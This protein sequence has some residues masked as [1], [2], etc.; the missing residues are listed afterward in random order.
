[1]HS[2][3]GMA[4]ARERSPRSRVR[5]LSAAGRPVPPGV[6]LAALAV[7]GAV[8]LLLFFLG[9]AEPP[10]LNA[11]PPYA[12]PPAVTANLMG[13][14]WDADRGPEVGFAVLYV[15]EQCPHCR[16]ELG[17]WA[18]LRKADEDIPLWIVASPGS[19]LEGLEWVPPGLWGRV[20][21][22]A[23]GTIAEALG[24][25]AVPVTL[26]VDSAGVVRDQ[27]L[28]A[29]SPSQIREEYRTLVASGDPG[30]RPAAA[31]PTH[32]PPGGRP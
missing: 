27:R 3:R 2:A 12:V 8:P 32:T 4:P 15:S 23:E 20:V 7:V 31:A 13:S 21:S 24:V 22:D 5:G 11:T 9:G 19:E 30:S 29:S 17:H 6:A 25:R 26:W 18:S 14:G 28:G 16:A 1:M 10:E